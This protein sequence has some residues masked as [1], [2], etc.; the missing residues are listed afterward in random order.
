[1]RKLMNLIL[2]MMFIKND[3]YQRGETFGILYYQLIHY[4]IILLF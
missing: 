3:S 4:Q 2:G 1:M